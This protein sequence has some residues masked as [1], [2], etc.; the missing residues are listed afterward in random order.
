M[1]LDFS[2][3]AQPAPKAR[4]QVGTTGTQAFMR[5]SASPVCSHRLGTDG[6]M[7][8][9][10]SSAQGDAPADSDGAARLNSPHVSPHCPQTSPAAE[11]SIHAV[12]PP[13][14]LVPSISVEQKRVECCALEAFE[15]RAAIM[16]FDG[17]LDREQAEMAARELLKTERRGHAHP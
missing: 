2:A 5:V 16:E 13:S 7:H 9:I 14:P 11:P 12:S 10:G 8:A 6:D 15:E 1:K 17:G 3:L 4:G